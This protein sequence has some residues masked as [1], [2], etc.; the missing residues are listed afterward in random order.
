MVSELTLLHWTIHMEVHP[1]ERL[2]S[3]FCLS[4]TACSSLSRNET[5]WNVT[6][7]CCEHAEWYYHCS[8]LV[9]AA[10]SGRDC[11]TSDLRLNWLLQS[12]LP[13]YLQCS[14]SHRCRNC[15]IHV[16]IGVVSP[17][18][19]DLRTV[20]LC[21]SLM[22]FICYQERL[23]SWGEVFT[24]IRGYKDKIIRLY[25]EWYWFRKVV[26]VNAFSSIFSFI[27]NR[28]FP[29]LH[30]LTIVSLS[31]LFKILST[32]HL[33]WIYSLSLIRK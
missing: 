29:T 15:D 6:L 14:L 4:F 7:L 28:F 27:D 2:F 24:L 19:V 8:S 32:F 13:I 18:S 11:F 12:F 10:I 5:P 26:A 30:S 17:G 20:H 33:M 1:C 22:V 16:F 23:I 3:F 25:K 9:Y 31:Q 21:F